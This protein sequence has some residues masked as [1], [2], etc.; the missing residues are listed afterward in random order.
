MTMYAYHC[1]MTLTCSNRRPRHPD[2][3]INPARAI[4]CNTSVVLHAIEG[5]H[6]LMQW[7][8]LS[9]ALEVM[10]HSKQGPALLAR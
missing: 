2:E 6:E 10:A 4:M 3:W 7:Y 9:P 8:A 5:H 1:N